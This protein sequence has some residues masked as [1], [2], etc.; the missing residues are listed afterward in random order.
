MKSIIVLL[1]FIISEISISAQ[2]VALNSDGS[3]PDNSAILD[4]KS[5][6]KG[7][8]V[9]RLTT[10]QR[11]SIAGPALGLIVFDMDTYS[12]WMYRGDVNGGWVELMHGFDKHWSKVGMHV[13]NTNSGNVGI[14][15]N[16]PASKLTIDGT[17]P[18]IGMMN[19]GLAIGSIQAAGFDFK[20]NTHPDNVGKIILGT[21]GNDHFFIDHLGR[22]SIGTPTASSALTI[23]GTTPK[24]Q[25][26]N[27]NVNK[28]YLQADWQSLILGTNST[29]TLGS[30]LLQTKDIPRIVIDANGRVGIGTTNPGSALTVAGTNPILQLRNGNSDKGFVQIVDN[31]LKIGTN[32]QTGNFIIKTNGADRMFVHDDGKVGINFAGSST[33]MLAVGQN[34]F[35]YTG[36]D[37]YND[38]NVRRGNLRFSNTDGFLRSEGTGTFNISVANAGHGIILHPEGTI[39]IGNLGFINGYKLSVYGKATASEFTVTALN[40]WPDYVFEK[41]YHLKPLSEVKK[42]IEQNKHLPNIPAAAEIEKSGVPLGDM[43][44]RLMEKVEELTLYIIQLQEQVDELKKKDNK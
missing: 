18:V 36:I 6:S 31:D 25:L 29:N 23:N 26:Q 7:L 37:F 15:T 8:L 20:I 16:M 10:L 43:S 24:L 5:S 21:R 1:I 9:P 28:G 4:I 19:N 30:L 22:V 38:L 12:F 39:S 27:E 13:F 32:T 3:Q 35:G 40:Q 44:K 33:H 34:A 41:D 42:F 11:T 14:G 17:D 2:S